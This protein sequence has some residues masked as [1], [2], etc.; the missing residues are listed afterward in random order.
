MKEDI[1]KRIF[2]KVYEEHPEGVFKSRK[3]SSPANGI[4][5]V[6]TGVRS[7]QFLGRAY[8]RQ[9]WKADRERR[10]RAYIAFDFDRA[11]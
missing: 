3:P 1:F 6:I 4:L 8:F 2:K 10:A 7:H 9:R 11:P 5:F